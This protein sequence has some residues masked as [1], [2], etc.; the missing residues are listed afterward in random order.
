M[1]LTAKQKEVIIKM[2]QGDSLTSTR[3]IGY[4]SVTIGKLIT[5]ENFVHKNTFNGLW[6]K[7]IIVF[8]SKKQMSSTYKL[9]ELGKT[10]KL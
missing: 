2:R 9:T 5:P 10:V 4:T 1:K 7:K 3:F 8:I 6:T